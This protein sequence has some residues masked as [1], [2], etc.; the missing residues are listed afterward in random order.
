MT[1]RE[2]RFVSISPQAGVG[3]ASSCPWT[4]SWKMDLAEEIDGYPF[5]VDKQQPGAIQMDMFPDGPGVT[6]E[7]PVGAQTP[8]NVRRFPGSSKK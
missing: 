3:K 8:N 7:V 5:L 1:G 4:R 2:R 6:S